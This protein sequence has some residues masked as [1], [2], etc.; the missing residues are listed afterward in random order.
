[1]TVR[2]CLHYDSLVLQRQSISQFDCL[3]NYSFICHR[4]YPIT[5]FLFISLSLQIWT[6]LLL[7]P[8]IFVHL[9][10]GLQIM[11]SYELL[12][13]MSTCDRRSL[14]IIWTLV[15]SVGA[16]FLV[17]L[18]TPMLFRNI[19]IDTL[20][21]YLCHHQSPCCYCFQTFTSCW[22]HIEAQQQTKNAHSD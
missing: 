9:P 13:F 10:L 20:F 17:D 11:K 22:Y 12:H 4:N 5:S 2:H 18:I 14:H 15:Q 8:L 6:F 16:Y 19:Q 1:M 21:N 7:L 3:D